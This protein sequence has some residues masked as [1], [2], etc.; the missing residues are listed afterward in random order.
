MEQQIHITLQFQLAIG[1]VNLNEIVSNHQIFKAGLTMA[2]P[3]T[4]P[5]TCD[6][7][8]I[9]EHLTSPKFS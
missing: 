6:T 8:Y 1:K 2:L 5:V 3:F 4:V 7:C 9:F